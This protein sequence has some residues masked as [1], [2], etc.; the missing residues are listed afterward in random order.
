MKIKD[1]DM[2]L[3]VIWGMIILFALIK[4]I[5]GIKDLPSVPILYGLI[6]KEMQSP[7]VSLKRVGDIISQD[8]SMSAKILQLVNSAFF[9]LP[10]KIIDPQQAAVYLGIETLKALILSIHVFSSFT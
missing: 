9:G 10:C 1:C 8:V 3:V 4:V 6:I 2:S 7:D 5:T